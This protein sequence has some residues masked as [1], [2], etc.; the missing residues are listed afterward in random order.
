MAVGTLP[1]PIIITTVATTVTAQEITDPAFALAI[2]GHIDALSPDE[3]QAF[4]TGSQLTP[5]ALIARVRDFDRMHSQGS[6]L[7]ACATKVDGFLTILDLYLKPL[8]ICIGHSP[9]ISS[10]VVG[11]VKLVIDVCW[12]FPRE[13]S[14]ADFYALW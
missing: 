7:R 2:K 14:V 10:L 8:A 1:V 9:G 6:R 13:T 5:Q 4:D 11:G 12:L 3:R